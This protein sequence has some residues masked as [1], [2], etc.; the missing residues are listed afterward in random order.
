MRSERQRRLTLALTAIV[1]SCSC[2]DGNMITDAGRDAGDDGGPADSGPRDAGRDGGPRDAAVDAGPSDPEW[3]QLQGLPTGCNVEVAAH[4]ERLG[5]LAWRPCF[6][7]RAGCEELVVDWGDWSVVQ[8]LGSYSDFFPGWG[9]V[10]LAVLRTL[11]GRTEFLV[12]TPETGVVERA[13]RHPVSAG[14]CVLGA[15]SGAAGPQAFVINLPTRMRPPAALLDLITPPLVPIDDPALD[16]RFVQRLSLSATGLIGLE[17]VPGARVATMRDGAFR[18]TVSAGFANHPIAVDDTLLF[19]DRSDT[20]VK[21]SKEDPGGTV[22]PYIA[23]ADTDV[24]SLASDGAWLAWLEGRTRLDSST[25]WATAA[26]MVARFEP[27]PAALVSRP[28]VDLGESLGSSI[29]VGGGWVVFDRVE[30]DRYVKVAVSIDTGEERIISPPDGFFF[31]SKPLYIT[32]D[33][34]AV[35]LV[36]EVSG[37]HRSI[38]RVSL[39]D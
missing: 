6:D 31:G 4:P 29:G 30:A 14:E 26:I 39:R 15:G 28:L 25:H 36:Q 32:T 7:G 8:T 38:W 24:M 35:P 20:Y 16:S 2:N 19:D 11:G 33:E 12:V 18:L 34:V 27:D 23:P 22:S 37:I 5:P 3:A 13:Y 1:A 9:G 21:V 10:A 17:I